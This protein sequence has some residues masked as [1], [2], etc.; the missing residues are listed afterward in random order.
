V[1]VSVD[2]GALRDEKLAHGHGANLGGKVQGRDAR[3]RGRV[4]RKRAALDEAA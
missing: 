1:V 4:D 2:V 3:D